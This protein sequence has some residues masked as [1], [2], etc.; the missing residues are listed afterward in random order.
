M[1]YFD[2]TKS[3]A[4]RH[5]SGLV[6]VTSRILEELGPR[7]TA[8]VW[9]AGWRNALTTTAVQPTPIDW[10]LTAELFSEGERP[11]FWAF[12]KKPPC[13]LAAIFHDAI[14]L[15]FPHVT[16][17]QSVSRHP[18]YMKML[19]SF[20]RVFAVSEASRRELVDFWH[21]QGAEV[22][23]R[24][25]TL[26]L[27][28]DYLPEDGGRKAAEPTLPTGVPQLLCL[29]II[30]P[31]KNQ[32]LLADVAEGLAKEGISFQLEIVGRVNPHFG[33]PIERRLAELARRYACIH[34]NTAAD[35]RAVA[36]LWR[37]ARASIFP[38]IAEG[39]GL[40]LLESLGVGV[41][42]LCSD[43]PVL[44]ENGE[45]G[46][47]EFIPV[48]DRLAWTAALRRVLTDDA[49]AAQL[50]REAA[51]RVV[52]KWRQTADKLSAHLV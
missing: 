7:A 4:A 48:N 2:I 23:A 31:R 47:C 13:R 49:Y 22:R 44:R 14:P 30:E 11:G 35:D 43:L 41:P 6:R 38:T 27:G 51:A 9:Q 10:L 5:R 50:R 33:G 24:V 40:P 18:E 8:V 26:L 25:E 46:G 45:G 36:Q 29:G 52:P 16:W 15:K 1:I 37:G 3:G 28:A 12:I 19:A 34:L 20:E 17:P 21:W 32:M 42:C 39:C